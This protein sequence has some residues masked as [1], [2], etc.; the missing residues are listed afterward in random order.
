MEELRESRVIW[1]ETNK[2]EKVVR[3]FP[4]SRNSLEVWMV[5]LGR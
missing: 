4:T 5:K 3:R 1:V 2:E